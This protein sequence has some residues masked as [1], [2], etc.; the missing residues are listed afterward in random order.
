[1]LN[2]MCMAEAI[3][4]RVWIW[5]D[6]FREW[7]IHTGSP[8]H[9]AAWELFHRILQKH[10]DDWKV[11]ELTKEIKTHGWELT[12]VDL[13]YNEGRNEVKQF[14]SLLHNRALRRLIFD[15]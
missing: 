3:Y 9:L 11:R 14:L 1:M 15:F 7:L 2:D 12:T 13:K 8:E 10:E 4:T 5:S 6:V